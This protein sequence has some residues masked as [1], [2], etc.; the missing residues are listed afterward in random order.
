MNAYVENHSISVKKKKKSSIDT[1][2]LVLGIL[3]IHDALISLCNIDIAK[4]LLS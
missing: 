3:S 4:K 2:V 1:E